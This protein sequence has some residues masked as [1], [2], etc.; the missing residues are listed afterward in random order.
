M[1]TTF[2]RGKEGLISGV[3]SGFAKKFDVNIFWVRLIWAL[4]ALWFGV[5][6]GFYL[7]LAVSLPSED[8]FDIAYE[9]KILGVCSRFAQKFN[10][11]VG[12]VRVAACMGLV[13]SFG[14]MIVAYVVCH[15]ILEADNKTKSN[16]GFTTDAPIK[17]GSATSHQDFSGKDYTNLSNDFNK[18]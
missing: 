13:C 12:L 3:C 5:G 17:P 16:T 8:K 14:A 1:T 10:F 18:K 2:Y 11:E 15:F 6:I 7:I 4:A 9:K